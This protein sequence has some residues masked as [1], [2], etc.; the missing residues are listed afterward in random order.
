MR[1][2]EDHALTCSVTVLAGADYGEIRYRAGEIAEVRYNGAV[3]EDAVVALV[4]L[5][6]GRFRVALPPLKLDIAGWPTVAREPTVPFRIQHLR[7][8]PAAG[9]GGRGAAAA[10][11][12]AGAAAAEPARLAVRPVTARAAPPPLPAAVLAGAP[13]LRRSPAGTQRVPTLQEPVSSA[14]PAASK[15]S[16]AWPGRLAARL[17]RLTPVQARL[18][19]FV[20]ALVAGLALAGA[21]A[22][23]QAMLG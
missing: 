6:A 7:A 1:H 19:A 18:L 4:K 22:I 16:L 9:E 20:S 11:P 13:A 12:P 3:D 10:A 23:V 5:A 21:V 17:L 2:C 8:T 15:G 14:A